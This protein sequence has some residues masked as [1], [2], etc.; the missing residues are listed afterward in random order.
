MSKSLQR[1]LASA[2]D[3]RRPSG[4]LVGVLL[5]N[6]A[7]FCW[8]TNIVLG[9]SLRAEIGPI[10]LA[11]L[12]LSSLFLG[13]QLSL[14]HLAGGGL[15]VGGGLWAARPQARAHLAAGTGQVQPEP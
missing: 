10:T 11:A 6:V 12:L 13:E 5:V 4:R 1:R 3:R 14:T 7:T 9:R 15:I 2:W 8:A